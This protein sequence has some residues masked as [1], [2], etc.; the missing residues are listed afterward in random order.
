MLHRTYTVDKTVLKLVQACLSIVKVC[1]RLCW[2][3]SSLLLDTLSWQR[4]PLLLGDSVIAMGSPTTKV[5]L[6][7]RSGCTT[8]FLVWLPEPSCMSVAR[9]GRGLVNNST[10]MLVH[11]SSLNTQGRRTYV[12]T[13]QYFWTSWLDWCTGLGGSTTLLCSRKCNKQ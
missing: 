1:K 13:H 8:L 6:N 7:C 4:P 11:K 9:K 2:Q 3:L 10:P 5:L 12:Y